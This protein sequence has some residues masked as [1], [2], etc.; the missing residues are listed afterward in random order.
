MKNQTVVV[1]ELGQNKEYS[2]FYKVPPTIGKNFYLLAHDMYDD[3]NYLTT[4]EVA[5]VV[6]TPFGWKF[7]TQEGKEYEIRVKEQVANTQKIGRA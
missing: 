7:K 6:E 3:N 5:S 4:V 1:R 2:G